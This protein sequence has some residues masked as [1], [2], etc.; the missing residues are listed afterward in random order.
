MKGF[1]G[2]IAAIV[3]I[4]ACGAAGGGGGGG[5]TTDD[6]PAALDV[7]PAPVCAPNATMRCDCPAGATGVQSCLGDAT[8]FTPCQCPTMTACVPGAT[9]SCACPSGGAMGTQT[10]DGAGA[11]YGACGPCTAVARCGDGVCNGTETCSTCPTDCMPCAMRCGD[12]VCNGTETCSSCS[13][14]CG[15]CMTTPRCGD[16]VCNLPGESCSSCSDDCGA[17]PPR[18]G[19][20]TCNG[21]ETCSSCSGDC[22]TCESTC[23]PCSQ[24]SDCAT[25]FC[26]TR[27]CDGVRGCYANDSAS[28]S[29]IGSV[30]CPPTSAYNVCVDSPECGP[31]AQCFR[32][33]D[34][35]ALCARR[36]TADRDC[37]AAPTGYSTLTPTCDALANRCYLRCNGPGS[38]P[39]GLSCF[40]Y[41]N[42]TY[43]FCS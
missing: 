9:R 25:G 22:G 37:P 27:R 16:G 21:T 1:L 18:C 17:C 34:G 30:R 26:G 28:C 39:F 33:G 31:Y 20:G 35:R 15:A 10:C 13:G 42:G 43:G 38:C 8:G 5:G 4:A 12:G 41:S 11:A 29:I 6:V 14:D 36:C 40:R 7:R 32:Y 23:M 2:L 3:C 19:D 24:D